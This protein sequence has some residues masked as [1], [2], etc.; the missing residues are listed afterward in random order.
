LCPLPPLFGKNLSPT[1]GIKRSLF[2]EEKK[3]KKGIAEEMRN[4]RRK[5]LYIPQKGKR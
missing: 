2:L 4:N 1:R 5:K 3:G